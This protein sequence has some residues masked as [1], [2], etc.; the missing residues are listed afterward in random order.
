MRTAIAK[1]GMI[2]L[3][4]LM[5]GGNGC[6]EDKVIQIVLTDE[7][8]ADFHELEDSANRTDP[9]TVDYGQEIR[10][11]LEKNGFRAEDIV[12]ASLISA[13]YGVRQR[14]QGDDWLL[15]GEIKVRRV[16]GGPGPQAT[17]VNYTNVSVAGALGQKILAN[18]DGAG[19]ALLNQ[20]LDDFLAG[21]N[22][23]LEFETVHGT[24]TP[25]PS[26]VSP[27]EFIWRAW[28]NIQVTIEDVIEDVPDPF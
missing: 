3:I 15:S 2:L 26:D 12:D 7:T 17:I 16:D 4:A 6:L 5:M 14:I 8:F 28:L 13:F 11:V 25:V 1:L 10:D 24:I 20:A 27:M 18:L 23:V 21:A 19:V 9:V 22:P